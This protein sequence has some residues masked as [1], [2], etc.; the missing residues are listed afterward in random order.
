MI[1]WM[2]LMANALVMGGLSFPSAN[3][4]FWWSRMHIF[5]YVLDLMM[6]MRAGYWWNGS[7]VGFLCSLPTCGSG[8]DIVEPLHCVWLFIW[9]IFLPWLNKKQSS[10]WTFAFHDYIEGSDLFIWDHGVT[11]SLS[12]IRIYCEVCLHSWNSWRCV[13]NILDLY[14]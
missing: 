1:L 13:F 12:D 7:W 5:D 4:F 2:Y 8:V 6:C 9:W 11:E 14:E 3:F 10:S